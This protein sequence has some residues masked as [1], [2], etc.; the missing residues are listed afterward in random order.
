M[1]D[2][3]NIAYR[4]RN[5][6][7]AYL[8]KSYRS[9][10]SIMEA[11]DCKEEED[12]WYIVYINTPEGQLSWHIPEADMDLFDGIARKEVV[13]DEHNTEEKH[14]R[15]EKLAEYEYYKRCLF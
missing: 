5:R 15:L 1:S 7:V 14:H 13:W 2:Q 6:L 10:S 8:A 3:A 11:P 9:L 12:K 4:E